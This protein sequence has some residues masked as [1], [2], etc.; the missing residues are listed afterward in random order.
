MWKKIP[1]TFPPNNS[2]YSH[3]DGVTYV[4]GC[5]RCGAVLSINNRNLNDC[6]KELIRQIHES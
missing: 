2:V 4:W 1:F 3:S 5:E 6:D